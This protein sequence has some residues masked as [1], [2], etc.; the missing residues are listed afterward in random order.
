MKPTLNSQ[1][2]GITPP[3]ALKTRPAARI[4]DGSRTSRRGFASMDPAEQR[5]IAS[6][7]GK[8]SHASGQGH[9]WT[10]E[11]ARAAGRKG[12]LTSRRGP[13]RP[14]EGKTPA[15]AAR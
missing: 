4:G 11:E 5:R 8:A 10:T 3:I 14:T 6:E 9:K 15:K 7:G 2:Q 13:S 12:G 1:P